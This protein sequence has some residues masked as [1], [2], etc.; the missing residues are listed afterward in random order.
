VADALDGDAKARQWITD[1]L[2]GTTPPS[3]LDVAAF[4]VAEGMIDREVVLRAAH[5]VDDLTGGGLTANIRAAKLKKQAESNDPQPQGGG[6][7]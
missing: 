1:N 5:I 4:E 3:L 2:L 6:G 7:F